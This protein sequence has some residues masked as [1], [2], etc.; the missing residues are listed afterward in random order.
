MAAMP[1]PRPVSPR[2]SVVVAETDTGADTMALNTAW[3]SSRRGAS[4]GLLPMIWM[5]MLPMTKPATVTIRAACA[6]SSTPGAPASSG[7]SVPK[8]VPRSPSPAAEKSASHAACEATS[9]SECPASPRSPGQVSPARDSVR[10]SSAYGWTS[11][12]TPIRGVGMGWAPGSAKGRGLSDMAA[13]RHGDILQ[14][15]RRDREVGRG[16]DL[17]RPSIAVDD[18]HVSPALL[19]QTGI[20]GGR[21]PAGIGPLEDLTQEPLGS[22]Y[23]AQRLAT[24]SYTHLRAH[25]TGRN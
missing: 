12:P 9:A 8:C 14:Q 25:E 10:S 16:G 21:G 18:M 1:S 2:P 4:R 17:E 22:L 15:G 5:A 20:I 23:A 3:A 7:R 24:V 19:D 13:I 11:T 6:S